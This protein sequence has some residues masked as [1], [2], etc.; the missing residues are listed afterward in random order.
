MRPEQALC[1]AAGA[2]QRVAQQHRIAQ[3]LPDGHGDIVPHGDILHQHRVDAHADH[4]EKRLEAQGQQGLQIVLPRL[5]PLTVGHRG[6]GDRPHG[7]GQ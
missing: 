2:K 5:A 1:E 3:T 7:Y 4:N 6:K